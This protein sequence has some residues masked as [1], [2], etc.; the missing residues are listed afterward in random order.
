MFL[1]QEDFF[2]LLHFNNLDKAIQYCKVYHFVD[3]TN[4]FHANKSLKNL[5]EPVNRDI[6]Q[7]NV[8][9]EKSEPIMFKSRR[10]VLSDEMK[11][12]DTKETTH[13]SNSVKSL[14]VRIDEF[15]YYCDQVNDIAVKLN[16]VN[17]LLLK[18]R[19]YVNMKTLRNIYFAIFDSHLT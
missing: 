5:N 6:K 16:R 8:N 15:F 19:T 14:G 18:S 11:I 3:D 12:K 13:S 4:L 9:A 7:L 1:F 10:K 17:V 2:F